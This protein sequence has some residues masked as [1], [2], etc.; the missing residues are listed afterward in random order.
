MRNKL[1]NF[2][3]FIFIIFN[4][5]TYLPSF[6]S[7]ITESS[8]EASSKVELKNTTSP[9]PVVQ[10]Q[11]E[12][13]QP[14]NMVITDN[15]ERIK[16]VSLLAH[17]VYREDFKFNMDTFI[18]VY[19]D[20]SRL[21]ELS[22]LYIENFQKGNLLEWKNLSFLI[23][24][25]LLLLFGLLLNNK[26]KKFYNAKKD[27]TRLDIHEILKKQLNFLFLL[28]CESTPYI[29][30][31][32][33][34]YLI[35]EGFSHY[36]IALTLIINLLW[37]WLIY[38]LANSVLKGLFIIG[39]SGA[40]IPP[41]VSARLYK[42]FHRLIFFSAVCYSAISIFKSFGYRLDFIAFLDILFYISITV[43]A[44]SLLFQ[45][46]DILTLFPVIDNDIYKRFIIIF[47]KFYSYAFY[48][49]VIL[50]LLWILGYKNLS[51]TLFMKSWAIVAVFLAIIFIH[52][53]IKDIL[54][55]YLKDKNK[56]SK[57]H[58][59]IIKFITVIEIFV[60]VY[61]VLNMLGIY[62]ALISALNFPIFELGKSQISLFPIIA[63]IIIFYIFIMVSRLLISILEE[64]VYPIFHLDTGIMH[65]INLSLH[66]FLVAIAVLTGLKIIGLDLSIITIFAGGLG[67]GIG[68]GLQNIA[69]NYAS[70][71]TIIFSRLLKKGDFITIEKYEG[72]VQDVGLK[73]VK[74][75]TPENI[76]L[77]IPSSSFVESA[78]VNFTYTEPKVRVHIPVHVSYNC[79]V[80]KLK[81]ILIK[82]ADDYPMALKE[83]K[84]EVWF[85]D[86]GE[87]SLD[88]ELLLWIDHNETYSRKIKG[89]INFLIWEALKENNI[90]VPYPQRDVNI[91]SN[92]Q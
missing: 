90:E 38:T 11:T 51:E 53:F 29:F 85:C 81:E 35:R 14:S 80:D 22:P 55:H 92:Y 83:P 40:S 9:S 56:P 6:S 2:F 20:L 5:F 86:F 13:K 43:I 78:T 58:V 71:M 84:P 31:I 48:F 67:V 62:N 89:E 18:N 8:P 87:S 76:D 60:L 1:F 10:D 59:Q 74:V 52:K 37:V 19:N 34:F 24:L 54:N 46:K 33:V 42:N 16:H 25:P 44:F 77:V 32:F 65:I 57:M 73:W 61:T 28:L 75:K 70:G 72:Y 4:F 69:K 49:T 50:A 41:D 79:D 26:I 3:F 64:K 27:M 36:N 21:Y 66:Y 39:I 23:F 45:K 68:F 63:A 17:L 12:L 47:D 30:L 15:S 88:F 82:V 91:R 7:Q